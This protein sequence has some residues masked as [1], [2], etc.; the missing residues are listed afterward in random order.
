MRLISKIALQ[1][2]LTGGQELLEEDGEP[3]QKTPVQPDYFKVVL[4]PD[5]R[6]IKFF[7]IKS[8]FSKSL[9]YP[10]ALQF[11]RNANRLNKLGV[12][13]P[14]VTDFFFCPAVMR[15]GVVYPL[16]QGE[17]LAARL[18]GQQEKDELLVQ[19]A[20]FIA[21]LH[22]KGIY[23]RALHMRNILYTEDGRMGLIDVT[24]A[25]FYARPL[26]LKQRKRNF[27]HIM[28][29]RFQRQALRKY[30]VQRFL[31][32]YLSASSLSADEA[33]KLGSFVD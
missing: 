1:E 26:N 19:L 13:A 32:K 15:Y 12:L 3:L 14:R 22:E 18:G 8:W 6:V 20:E 16:I 28:K 33:D 17:S 2:L 30:G 23:F 24:D 21:L 11:T 25:R 31:E 4:T 5:D 27:S 10:Y 29:R 9:I 7:R